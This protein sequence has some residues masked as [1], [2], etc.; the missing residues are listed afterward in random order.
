VNGDRDTVV[1]SFKC[2]RK[3]KE[4]LKTLA[5][6]EKKNISDIVREAI[7]YAVQESLLD[8]SIFLSLATEEERRK[9][10]KILELFT[11]IKKS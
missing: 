3:M 10:N 2:D 4:L 7:L 8:S 5:E 11:E 9:Y 1:I 6:L